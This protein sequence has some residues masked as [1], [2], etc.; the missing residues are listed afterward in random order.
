VHGGV[1]TLRRSVAWQPCR[2]SVEAV[3]ANRCLIRLN[4]LV[5]LLVLYLKPWATELLGL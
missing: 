5:S 3:R 2:H 1:I 4:T